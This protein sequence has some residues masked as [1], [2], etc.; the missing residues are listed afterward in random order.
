MS[1]LQRAVKMLKRN[2]KEALSYVITLSV[3]T[4]LLF[5]FMNVQRDANFLAQS[6]DLDTAD[7][8][9]S[10]MIGGSLTLIII[11]ICF[12][13]TFI[14]NNYFNHAKAQELCVYLS[15]GMNV[16]EL[17][18]YLLVQNLILLSGAIVFGGCLGLLLHMGL[19]QLIYQVMDFQGAIVTLTWQGLAMWI[20]VLAIE[21]IF[22][23]LMNVGY[24]YKAELKDL[25]IEARTTT[26]EDKRKVH[27]PPIFYLLCMAGG[28]LGMLITGDF[29]QMSMV[30]T[31]IGML[32]IHGFLHNGI[33]DI[34]EKRKRK[35]TT[36]A[37]QG[38]LM[39][40]NFVNLMNCNYLYLLLIMA[41]VIIMS[42]LEN[43]IQPFPY[44]MISTCAAYILILI[45]M[46][47]SMLFK[48]IM[49][50]HHRREEFQIL[51]L[52]GA[53]EREMKECAIREIL[54]LFACIL[55]LPLLYAVTLCIISVIHQVM[56]LS[57]LYFMIGSY[58]GIVIVCA[59]LSL[60]VYCQ[61]ALAREEE[62]TTNEV[63]N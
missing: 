10:N 35:H 50:A 51:R 40:S 44:L 15:S 3:T 14:V 39:Q 8:L 48:I 34:V 25:L 37:F 16:F 2:K 29:L 22:L 60:R 53:K 55:F 21:I 43:I 31:L 45:V 17:T 23:V 41:S 47:I 18:R 62:D 12:A 32:G 61:I 30:C 6:V 58:L 59:I 26:G 54:A 49:L 56:D 33:R 13:N 42:C 20:V 38:I 27:I 1:T 5:L 11:A 46:S 36:L 63:C 52:M 4:C 28:W 24:A 7:Q 19:N 57:F 9:T